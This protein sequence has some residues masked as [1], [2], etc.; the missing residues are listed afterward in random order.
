MR[1]ALRELKRH[2]INILSAVGGRR[3]ARAMLDE[4]LVQDLYLTTSA[5]S[6]GEPNTP[7]IDGALKATPVVVKEGTGPEAGVRFVH[8]L[9]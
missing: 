3:T 7:L 5:E 2:G 4:G 9:C 1:A 8:Y 6:S